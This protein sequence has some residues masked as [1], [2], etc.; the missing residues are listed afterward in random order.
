M[1]TRIKSDRL[2]I[3]ETTS[4]YNSSLWGDVASWMKWKNSVWDTVTMIDS[5]SV[6]QTK[7]WSLT[8]TWW[9]IGNVTGNSSTATTL[10]TSRSVQLGSTSKSFNGSQNLYFPRYEILWTW[11]TWQTIIYNWYDWSPWNYNDSTKLPLS[12]WTISGNLTVTWNLSVTWTLTSVNSTNM[13]VKDNQI[14]INKW[15][16]WAGVTAGIAWIRVDRWTSTAYDIVFEEASWFFKIWQVGSYQSVATREDTPLSGGFAQWDSTTNKFITVASATDTTKM[17]LSGW[18]FTWPVSGTTFTWAFSW[19]ATTATTLA[20][21]RTINWTSFNGS[22][23]IT[24]A[25]WWTARTITLGATGKSIDGSA[26]VSYSL[27]EILWAWTTWQAL[28]HNWTTWVAWTY[29]DTTK[30]PLAWGTFTWAVSWTT[31]SG[32]TFTWALS[33]NATTATTL[34]TARTIQTNLASTSSVSFNGSANI[35]PWV[36]WILAIGNGWTGIS[37]APT[38]WWVAYWASATAYWFSAVGTSGQYL[39]SNWASAPSWATLALSDLPDAFTKKAV[40]CRTTTNLAATYA[41]NVLTMS[42]VWVV[43]LDGIT[44]ALGERVAICDQTTPAHNGIYTVTTLGTA[45]VAW[46]FTRAT[47]ANTSAYIAGAVVNIDK[48]T[49]WSGTK[50]TTDFKPTDTLGTTAMNWYVLLDSSFAS[51]TTPVANWTATIGTSTTYARADHVHPSTTASAILSSGTGWIWYTTWAGW[52]VTQ[53]TSRTTWVTL[54]K[55]TWLITLFSTTTTAWQVTTFT[56]TNSLVAVTDTVVVSM[57]TATWIYIP[58]VTKTVAW[59]FNIS[60]YTPSAVATAEAP[61]VRFT[62]IK[63]VSA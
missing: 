11:T 13:E 7:A 23:N 6:A 12:G 61:T 60:I 31:F 1:T 53:A 4:P 47:D 58:T 3:W 10:Q 38:V 5:S 22:A 55:P 39:K 30:M 32:T 21:A 25:N 27:T 24:T 20:T 54:A 41:S 46:V 26:A 17:P 35:T 43:T 28:V 44:P 52:V 15:E 59:S 33:G 57:V 49:I 42:A 16:T 50:M 34:Q 51:S 63:S 14:V 18:T 40:T 62:V 29:D 56:V 36:T 19:N 45:S 37:T 8:V 2:I 9:V 48:G